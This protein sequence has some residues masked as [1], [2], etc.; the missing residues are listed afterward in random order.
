[1]GLCRRNRVP[2][3]VPLTGSCP[4]GVLTLLDGKL[5]VETYYI[6]KG[7]CAQIV[8]TLAF[9]VVH[10]HIYILLLL[11]LLLLLYIYIYI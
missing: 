4:G 8:Y 9:E 10:T 3:R 7:S 2:L 1:M 6:P 11:I 5:R